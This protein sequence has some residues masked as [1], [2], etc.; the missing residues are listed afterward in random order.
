MPNLLVLYTTLAVFGVGVTIVDFL[1]LMDHSD[2]DH[3]DTD[4]SHSDEAGDHHDHGHDHAGSHHKG[5]SEAEHGV[6]IA[7][8]KW[9]ELEQRR[10]RSGIKVL[11]KIIGVLRSIVYFS[12]GFGPTGLFAHFTGQSRLSGLLWAC[13]V[14]AAMIALARFLRRFIRKDLDSSIK[15]DEL[16]EEEGVLLL[17]LEGKAISK[18]TVRQFGREIEIFVRSKDANLKLPKGK[19]I[20]ITNYDNDVYWVVPVEDEP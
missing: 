8:E 19:K 10:E 4:T 2:T 12:L 9:P 17:P 20:A 14:G 7:K 3:G 18:A 11:T 6:F 15:P 1:G 16:L 13:G 5:G